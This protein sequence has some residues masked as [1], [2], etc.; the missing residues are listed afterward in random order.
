[1]TAPIRS[2]HPLSL[3][4][5]SAFAG[6]TCAQQVEAGAPVS[7]VEIKGRSAAYDPRR[8]DTATRSV[9]GREE[10]SRYGDRSVLDALKRVPGVTVNTSQARGGE[11][12]MRGLGAGY[13]QILINGE[14]P[15]RGF[16][17]DSLSPE[18][19]ERIEVLRAATADLS[20]QSVAGTVNI[21]LRHVAKKSERQLKLGMLRSDVFKGPNA[22][23]QLS[24]RRDGFAWS[25]AA[26]ATGE[27]FNRMSR[28][29]EENVAP[30]GAVDIQ[31]T[32]AM[33]EEGRM[34]RLNLTP[35]LEWTLD[36][37]DT[38]VLKTFINVNR[39]RNLVDARVTTLTGNPRRC[40]PGLRAGAAIPKR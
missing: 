29:W 5:L 28:I 12:Q 35:R 32:T 3:I 23:L 2:R 4:M 37:G 27:R 33:P 6:P 25:L 10:L 9:I 31:R 14:R 19:V 40:R 39:F 34:R 20:T 11:I 24:N 7:Q 13:T 8:D 38:V 1:V 30:G 22:A 26:D 18:V 36:G 16:D 15:P 21:I 17:F